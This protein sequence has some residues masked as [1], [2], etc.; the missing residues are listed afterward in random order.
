MARLAALR[1]QLA[2]RNVDAF[3]IP[4]TDAHNSEYAAACFSRRAYISSF[5]GSA[6][7][8]VVTASHAYL[9]TDGRYFLQA[10]Q[11]LDP[12]AWQL[13]R[14]GLPD[15]PT[16]PQ[17]LASALPAGS[18]VAVDPF[19]H[20]LDAADA[21]ECALRDVG[22]T[23]VPLLAPNPVDVV[24]GTD[25]PAEPA[26]RVR[27]HHL[28]YAG[29]SVPDKLARVR[30]QMTHHKVDYMLC[31]MLDETAWLFNIRGDDIPHCPVVLSYALVGPENAAL[32]VDATKLPAQVVQ[33]LQADGVTVRPYETVVPD[34][35]AIAGGGARVWV[36]PASTSVALGRAA[37]DAALRE[38]TPVPLAKA[39]KNDAE[40]AGMRE[41]HLKDGVALSSFLCWLEDAVRDGGTLSEVAAA[42]RLEEFRAAQAGF[43][44]TSFDT[45]AGSGPNGA[46]IHYSPQEPTCG[47]VSADEVFLLDSGGQYVDGTT[48]VT[49]TVYMGNS[50]SVYEC[51]CF[52]RVLKGH[53]GLDSAVF[54]PRTTGLMLDIL[55]RA[56]LWS[57]GL[58]YRHGTGHG[59]GACLNV[60]EGPQSISPRAGSN[61]TA[62]VDGMIVS[63]EPGY[64]EDGKFGIRI[65]N[66]LIIEKKKTEFAFG[67]HDYLAF[68]R[69]TFVPIDK[70]MI[71]TDFLSADEIGWL[72]GYHQ[73]VWDKLSPRVED[74][75]VREWLWEKTR[76]LIAGGDN[77]GSSKTREA[78]KIGLESQ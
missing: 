48:D 49:R 36:D 5:T 39:R 77:N 52:T 38:Q 63:N 14:A 75:R 72:D 56:P 29:E 37:G 26:G 4:S 57:A 51:E 16:I 74:K 78:S 32:Y 60:H 19:L 6:G 21:L 67:G 17:F 18:A 34:V 7:T 69:L 27:S 30:Q 71:V 28:R 10:E 44:G 65:E 35:G 50:A 58:D 66:L 23:L 40:L 9:W 62:L 68:E 47:Q 11:Q 54:P 3:I 13:M 12:S 1:T 55:A 73:Q 45:I 41:A 25:R 42:D 59:V 22:S 43:L 8:V 76:P 53:I 2:Q 70:G 46:I 24:W 61:K 20:S 31:S 33:T 64:Y 15:T